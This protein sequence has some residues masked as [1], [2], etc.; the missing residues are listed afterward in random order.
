[1]RLSPHPDT[2]AEP[3]LGLE[4]FPPFDHIRLS[5]ISAFPSCVN[6]QLLFTVSLHL[7]NHL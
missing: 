1:M 3:G 6:L 7:L 2:P 4:G 5:Y